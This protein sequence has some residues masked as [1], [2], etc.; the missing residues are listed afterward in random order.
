MGWG[1]LGFVSVLPGNSKSHG[2][3]F[4]WSWGRWFAQEAAGLSTQGC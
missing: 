2:G 1:I 3:G 4:G